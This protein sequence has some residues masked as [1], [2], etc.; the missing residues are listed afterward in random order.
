MVHV[1]GDTFY[2]DFEDPVS[3]GPGTPVSTNYDDITL[4][5]EYYP[6]AGSGHSLNLSINKASSR[7]G[8]PLEAPKHVTS[9]ELLE[10]LEKYTNYLGHYQQD[11]GIGEYPGRQMSYD[12]GS[13][14]SGHSI[15]S[16]VHCKQYSC[17]CR[18][19]VAVR[20]GKYPLNERGNEMLDADSSL[21]Y[22]SILS[23]SLPELRSCDHHVTPS[24]SSAISSEII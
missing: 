13:A 14:F 9:Q 1:Q 15:T 11:S 7:E 8:I 12:F 24:I 10:H 21:P 2:S 20:E 4:Y 23:M 17:M 18:L 6:A 16:Y 3:I 5:E 19:C 22:I